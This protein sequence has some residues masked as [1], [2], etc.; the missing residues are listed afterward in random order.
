MPSRC[1]KAW[2]EPGRVALRRA[3]RLRVEGV[4]GAESSQARHVRPLTPSSASL[5]SNRRSDSVQIGVSCHPARGP[6]SFSGG[7]C[8]R[9]S[10]WLD[11]NGDGLGRRY[12]SELRPLPAV[13]TALVKC[14]GVHWPRPPRFEPPRRLLARAK[15]GGS[16]TR[17]AG[18]TLPGARSAAL[19]RSRALSSRY[20][21]CC[22][23]Q[24]VGALLSQDPSRRAQRRRLLRLHD[25]D[26]SGGQLG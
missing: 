15:P 19:A 3:R 6:C 9:L 20:W 10:N 13:W 24:S 25:R 7:L 14:E 17:T 12:E 26:D 16:S 22:L 23:S 21:A 1:G 4:A 5:S 8:T 11:D 2:H 18:P